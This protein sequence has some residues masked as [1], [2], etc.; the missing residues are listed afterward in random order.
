M[1]AYTEVADP[2]DVAGAAPAADAA[3][4]DFFLAAASASLASTSAASVGQML[5]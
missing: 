4:A 5:W 3:G 2:W 1:N